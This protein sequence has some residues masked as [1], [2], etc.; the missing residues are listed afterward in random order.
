MTRNCLEDLK[1]GNTTRQRNQGIQRK[2]GERNEI[3][4]KESR[5]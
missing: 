1:T 4:V 2:E 3:F 5:N